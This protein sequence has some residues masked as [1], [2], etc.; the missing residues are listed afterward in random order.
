MIICRLEASVAK[1]GRRERGASLVEFALLL[2]LLV[3]LVF[4]IIEF[5]WLF[6]QFNDV[7]H[8]TREGARFA[9]VNAGDE[10]A[11]QGAVCNAMEGLSAGMSSI[12]ID[13][14]DSSTVGTQST[15]T[16]TANVTSLS[17]VPLITTFLPSQLSSTVAFRLEQP[18]TNWNSSTGS[19]SC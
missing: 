19:L 7:R 4:G 15:I 1:Q 16:V 18:S 12:D 11:I 17:G 9:A 13:L 6:G 5:G 3:L 2:P 10:A 8:G 14:S